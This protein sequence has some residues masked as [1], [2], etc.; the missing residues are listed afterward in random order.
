MELQIV[1]VKKDAQLYIQTGVGL[2][3]KAS[4]LAITKIEDTQVANLLLKDCH[5]TEREIENKRLEIVSMPNDFIREVNALF[6]DVIAP[7][8]NAKL[9]IKQ[10]IV[11]YNEEQ[12]RI[13]REEEEKRRK[14]EMERQRKLDEERRMREEE[15]RK[16]REQEEA[17]LAEIA[18]AQSAERFALEQE[19]L[20]LEREKRQAEEERKKLLEEK[21]ELLRKQIEESKQAELEAQ[22]KVKGI[23]KRWTYEIVNEESVPRG[24]CSSDSK[25]INEAIK[26]GIRSIDGVRIYETQTVR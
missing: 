9:L 6:K 11:E 24:Y 13:R 4:K 3:E 16:I 21:K 8:A 17:R 15:E 20:A 25:K 22:T 1:K 5:A 14:E 19:R 12:E 7:V 2:Q 10:K 18:R 23:M 26:N